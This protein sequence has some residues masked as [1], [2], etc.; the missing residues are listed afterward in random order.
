M[1]AMSGNAK[2]KPFNIAVAF[3][4]VRDVRAMQRKDTKTKKRYLQPLCPDFL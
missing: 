2:A 3:G 4:Y 1:Y